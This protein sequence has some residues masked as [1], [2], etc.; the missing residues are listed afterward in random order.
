V[1][2]LVEW[3]RTGYY[4]NYYS[5]ILNVFYPLAIALVLTLIGLTAERFTRK[6]RF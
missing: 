4:P 2:H 3:V 5:E 1:L 6:K